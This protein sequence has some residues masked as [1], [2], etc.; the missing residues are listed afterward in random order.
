M[1][2]LLEP[3][4]LVPQKWMSAGEKKR[5][6]NVRPID[7]LMEFIADRIAINKNSFPVIK[8]TGIGS[9][10]IVLKSGT[11]SGKSTTIPPFLYNTFFEHMRKN[12]AVTQPRILTA[13]D[14]P[15]QIIQY[16]KNLKVGENI[17]YQTGTISK[18]IQKGITFMTV[19]TLLQ[20]LKIMT[21]EELIA[22]YSF[23]IIDEVHERSLEVDSSLFYIKQFLSRN[24]N[25]PIC[26][27]VILMSATFD[28]DIFMTYYGCPKEHFIQI[29]GSTYPIERHFAAHDVTDYVTYCVDLV[30]KLHIENYVDVIE[31][32][33][34]RDILIFVQGTAPMAAITEKLHYLNAVIL[35]KSLKEIQAHIDEQQKKYTGG[36]DRKNKNNQND[37]NDQNKPTYYIAPIALNKENF[38]KGGKDYKDLFSDIKNIQVPIYD[39]TEGKNGPVMTD[40]IVEWVQAGRRVII[41][42]NVAETGVTIDTLRYC[43]DTGW[44]KTSEFNPNFG[45]N[46]L[47]DKNVTKAA[48]EQRRGRVGRKAPGIWYA[49]YTEDSLN[50]FPSLQFPDIV[51][52][53][54]SQSLLSIIIG[55]TET[56]LIEIENG[57]HDAD[58]FQMNKFDQKW[59]KV[60]SV[61]PFD[62]SALD[63]VQYPSA[64]SVS[65]GI[66][67]LYGL[68]FIDH[69]YKPTLFGWFASKFRKI[70]LENIRMI[71]AAY[72]Y[73]AN[74]LDILTIACC[75]EVGFNIGIKKRKYKPR[76]PLGVTEAEAF[77]YYKLLF[78]DEFIEYLFIWYD[79]M[80]IIGKIGDILE[81]N[82]RSIKADKTKL[83]PMNYLPKW[84]KENGF[85]IEGLMK[86]VSLRDELIADMLT[87]G[88]NPYYNGLDLPRGTYDLI[89][90]LRRNLNEGIDEIRKIKNCIYEGYRFNLCVRDDNVKGY[91]S[92]Y[93]HAN[94]YLDS[95]LIKPTNTDPDI[96][97]IRPQKIIVSDITIRESM[98][99]KGNYE[100]VGGDISVLDGYVD[101]DMEF[102]MH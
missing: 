58:C 25:K 101:V 4:N 97:Q 36:K 30:E 14:I 82:T 46:M 68:G 80:S 98:F 8:P 85:N 27:L 99:N 61:K 57:A 17:G 67:K 54:I 90:I 83:M 41:A 94:I 40:T 38:E 12:I 51:S 33:V 5:I 23:I 63:F 55:E 48:A 74:A 20:H 88:L 73:G 64:D 59:Y 75:I 42:T 49:C 3:G 66:E 32:K 100:F 2:T 37:K 9:R 76:N 34:S 43:I 92:V 72:Q 21:D 35:S 31:D 84:C 69:E 71:L 24:W 16:N 77:Y 53:D 45:C 79:F 62:A 7:Y 47:L 70:K 102:V 96:Q 22:K 39:F 89:N 18:K 91:V 13:V 95:H 15:Y 56:E 10:V 26:P 86:I 50:N 6:M 11:G 19:G 52:S 1:P 60:A 78:Y 28:P 29:S 44:V 93:S 81:K 87:M 65:Y